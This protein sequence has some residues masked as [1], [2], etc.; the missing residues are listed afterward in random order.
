[1]RIRFSP[2]VLNASVS[3]EHNI[4]HRHGH[5]IYTSMAFEWRVSSAVRLAVVVH[6]FNGSDYILFVGDMQTTLAAFH[7]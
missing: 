1:M 2:R 6:R 4:E 5:P 7:L 3:A